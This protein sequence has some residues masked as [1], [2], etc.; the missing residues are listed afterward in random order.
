MRADRA[1]KIA[2]A[3][4]K[5]ATK[6]ETKADFSHPP[7]TTSG[8]V[9]LTALSAIA[10]VLGAI[11]I[12]RLQYAV[13][14][15]FA[16]TAGVAAFL[17]TACAYIALLGFQRRALAA[18]VETLEAQN[19]ALADG[20][21]ELREEIEHAQSLIETQGDLIV[22]RDAMGRITY[23]NNAYCK[24][25][26]KAR[27]NLVG[28]MQK[29]PVAIQ[30]NIN[31]LPD[32]SRTH[33]QKIGTGDDARWIAWHDVTVRSDAGTEIQSVGRDMTARITLEREQAA[34]REQAQAANRAKSQF[35][36]M[37]SHEI[38]TPLNGIL[39][40]SDLLL[41][42]KL[43]PEQTNYARAARV[44]GETLLAL[45]EDVLD[46]SK[47]EAG[48]FTIEQRPFSLAHLVEDAVELLAPRAQTKGIEIASFVDER[49]PDEV[50]GDGARLR[51]VLLNLAGNAV[52]FTETGGV[53]IIVEPAETAGHIRLCVRDTGIG[54]KDEDKERVFLDFEQ[55]DNSSTRKFGGTGL[56]LAVSKRLVERMD[57]AIS[58]E[59]TFGKGSTFSVT[60][61][62]PATAGAEV[63]R[64][65]IPDLT[66]ASVMIVASAQVE[67][68]LL[69]RRLTR[70]GAQVSLAADA[71]MAAALLPE[72]TWHTMLVDH[73]EAA[74]L[75]ETGALR[76][77]D[78]T[79]RIVL[80]T[81]AQRGDL[82]RLRETGFDGYLVKPVRAVSLAARLRPDD[83]FDQA[84]ADIADQ[85]IAAE[86]AAGKDGLSILVAED[87]EINAMLTRAL[88]TK[89]G[90][91]PTMAGDGAAAVEAWLAARAAN[92]PFDLVLMDVQMPG[93]DGLAAT[94]QIRAVELEGGGHTPVV[95]LT[96]SAYAEDR[97]ACAAAG[98]DEVLVKPLDRDRLTALL[99]TVSRSPRAQAA[100]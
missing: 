70:W 53:A 23:A 82:G 27:D 94:R 19:E 34:T 95:A 47:I 33:D 71:A 75:V 37:V 92:D 45:I 14:D 79:R 63:A 59:S 51:Q 64:F 89:L 9:V 24:L 72:R 96:A 15:P 86:P 60:L 2:V 42:T 8:R 81:P 56:G 67:A 46:F 7:L 87:N 13:T 80:I 65:D 22:R 25:A 11:A 66:G 76:K 55:A 38:R 36:A 48:K 84:A 90:H 12:I 30:A 62:L 74:A 85:S 21:W 17:A 100:A 98:M 50:T 6:I 39:G 54:L 44:S 78:D 18:R 58:V 3:E 35:L 4:P 31:V 20:N 26:G 43:T 68:S 28:T 57:G 73:A 32:G 5:I 41:D 93:T 83:V 49:L 52:K 77:L 16:Y 61:P 99:K 40:M 69:A 29:L 91:R 97:D 1:G 88:L 10:A